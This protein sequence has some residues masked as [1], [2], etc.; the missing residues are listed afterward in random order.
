MPADEVYTSTGR[1]LRERIERLSMPVPESGCWIWMG[2]GVHRQGYG[3]IKIG[4]R[5]GKHKLAHRISY[6][7]FRGPIPDGL[8]VCHTCDVPACVNPNHLFLGTQAEN[9]IDC[10]KKGRYRTANSLKTH[11]IVGHELVGENLYQYGNKRGCRT[12]RRKQ[13]LNYLG[14]KKQHGI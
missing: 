2:G 6:E 4:G 9:I 5:K 7:A 12:C 11:C 10:K 8:K 13:Y 3:F 1:E 14:R